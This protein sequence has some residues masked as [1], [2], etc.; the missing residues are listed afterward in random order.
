MRELKPPPY[1]WDYENLPNDK[2]ILFFYLRSNVDGVC[3]GV[4]Y[5]DGRREYTSGKPLEHIFTK[6]GETD[7]K[8]K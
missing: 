8:V 6:Q 3:A 2:P 1:I 7:V 5:K 4:V